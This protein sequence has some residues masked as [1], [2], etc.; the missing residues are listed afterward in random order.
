MSSLTCASMPSRRSVRNDFRGTPGLCSDVL[1]LGGKARRE[2]FLIASWCPARTFFCCRSAARPVRILITLS[3]ARA[4]TAREVAPPL[5][6]SS[7]VEPS[8]YDT[9]E[10]FAEK[11]NIDGRLCVSLVFSMTHP[12]GCLFRSLFFEIHLTIN[13][14]GSQ[15]RFAISITGKMAV[16]PI[17][18]IKSTMAAVSIS[19][20]IDKYKKYL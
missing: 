6:R 13:A 3:T 5:A 20:T 17:I 15:S 9:I 4:G 10:E 7:A 8:L 2:S 18:R 1:F 12:G 16:K 14:I 19:V 11:A